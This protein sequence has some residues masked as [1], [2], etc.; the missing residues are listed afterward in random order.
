MSRGP[1]ALAIRGNAHPYFPSKFPL[2]CCRYAGRP[3][4]AGRPAKLSAGG[5]D[6]MATLHALRRDAATSLESRAERGHTLRI[7]TAKA[8]GRL[9]IVERNQVHV[10]GEIAQ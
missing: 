10:A 3:Q 6:T 8:F 5:A 4:C 9:H 2:Q 7:G 1:V